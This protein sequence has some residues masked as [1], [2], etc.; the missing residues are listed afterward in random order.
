MQALRLNRR[1]LMAGAVGLGLGAALVRGKPEP[2]QAE[3]VRGLRH[4]VWVW[5]FDRDGPAGDIR[6]DLAA[7]KLGSVAERELVAQVVELS[8]VM[9]WIE[10]LVGV[11]KD[12][13]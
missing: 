6:N 5:Q 10:K 2:A 1:R 11:S 4:L 9:S 8:D 12:Q 7:K 3:I 13:A